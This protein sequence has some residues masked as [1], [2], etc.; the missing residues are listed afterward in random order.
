MSIVLFDIRQFREAT[1]GQLRAEEEEGTWYSI[2]RLPNHKP[3]RCKLWSCLS[4]TGK[5]WQL[6]RGALRSRQTQ[7]RTVGRFSLL[8]IVWESWSSSGSTSW[9]RAKTA[10]T[11]PTTLPCTRSAVS[12]WRMSGGSAEPARCSSVPVRRLTLPLSVFTDRC[13]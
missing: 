2:H 7:W 10:S 5:S 8:W 6:T 1:K 9:T 12:L 11:S 4:L 3:Y 13:D